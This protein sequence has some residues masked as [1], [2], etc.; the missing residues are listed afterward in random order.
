MEIR[1]NDNG[2]T[3]IVLVEGGQDFSVT[4]EILIGFEELVQI[5]RTVLANHYPRATTTG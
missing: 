1:K 3:V 4:T 5:N 2:Q